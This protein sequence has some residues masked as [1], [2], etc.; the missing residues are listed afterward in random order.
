ML[1]VYPRLRR[2]ERYP[3]RGGQLGPWKDTLA[4]LEAGFPRSRQELDSLFKVAG[5]QVSNGICQLN[6]EPKSSSARRMMPRIDVHFGTNDFDLRATTLHFGDGSTLRNDFSRS[7]RNESIDPALFKPP[8]D[9]GFEIV[10]PLK[11]PARR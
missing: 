2:A 6:L 4:L 8:V 7:R 3:L 9:P 10:E 1:V 11:K 5:Q